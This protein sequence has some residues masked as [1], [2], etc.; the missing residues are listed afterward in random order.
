MLSATRPQDPV[1]SL[2]ESNDNS[3]ADSERA[4]VPDGLAPAFLHLIR[5]TPHVR[6]D[7]DEVKETS[8]QKLLFSATLTRDPSKIA[9][10]NLRDPKYFLV[11][12]PSVE[13][14]TQEEGVL[15]LVMEK[16][17][18]PDTLSVRSAFF[19]SCRANPFR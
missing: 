4:P 13:T 9:A 11:Q 3:A 5:K 15:D 16:F 14:A 8:C 17:S 19:K 1:P 18:M 7:L 6:T 12:S 2:L 10:L